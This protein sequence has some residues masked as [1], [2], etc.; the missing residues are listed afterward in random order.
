M[1]VYE[2]HSCPKCGR[3]LQSMVPKGSMGIGEPFRECPKC[4]TY[5]IIKR[6][7]NEWALMTDDEKKKIRRLVPR[8]AILIG[9]TVGFLVG[10]FGGQY[11]LGEDMTANGFNFI[12]TLGIPFL[13]GTFIH[14]PFVK[15]SLRKSIE[16]SNTRMHDPTYVH[17]LELLGLLPN[18]QWFPGPTGEGK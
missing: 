2:F 4:G 16:E 12:S 17:K 1:G 8:T 3:E 9:G 18:R 6:L 13:A 10:L 15:R 5:V 7:F 14:Y 11:L